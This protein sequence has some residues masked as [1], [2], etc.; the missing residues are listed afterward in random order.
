MELPQKNTAKER[1]ST[2]LIVEDSFSDIEIIKWAFKETDCYDITFKKSLKE[3]GLFLKD[4]KVDIILTD[5]YLSDG[6]GTE[7]IIK[8]DDEIII[9]TILMT[10][11]GSEE[12]AITAFKS[13]AFD[14]I[15][16][17]V[18]NIQNLPFVVGRVLREWENIVTR[19]KAEESLIISEKQLH[20]IFKES[21]NAICIT[22]MKTGRFLMI[23]NSFVNITGFSKNEIIGNYI[24]KVELFK[25]KT[26][27]NIIID[28]IL[29]REIIKNIEVNF[30]TK[31]KS[32]K[33]GLLSSVPILFDGKDAVLTLINDITAKKEYELELL[34]YRV[35]LE[36][37][38]EERTAELDN[39]IQQL[40]EE[41]TE[42]ERVKLSLDRSMIFINRIINS[43]GEPIFV[44]DEN[45]ELILF[46]EALCSL[47]GIE[48]SSITSNLNELSK[49]NNDFNIL[50][51]ENNVIF[52]FGKEYQC[53]EF[54]LDKEGT[55]RYILTHKALYCDDTGK[56]FIVGIISDLS[57]RKDAEEEMKNAFMKEKELNELKSRF[58]S[59]VSHEYRTPL[60][61][62]MSSAELLQMFSHKWDKAKQDELLIKIQ[63][64]VEY[65]TTLIDDVLLYNVLDTNRF[66]INKEAI[67]VVSF[68]K[69]IVNELKIISK[70]NVTVN[71]TSNKESL[72]IVSDKKFLL[73]IF[74][75]LVTNAIK[76]SREDT[77]IHIDLYIDGTVLY[78]SVEDHGYGIPESDKNS[79]F[80]PFFRGKNI[81]NIPGS[82]LGLSIVKN[83]L[84]ILKGDITYLSEE[85]VGTRFIIRI[86]F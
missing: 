12:T 46:N 48:R 79:L 81:S 31:A 63:E 62:I 13:G 60:T 7:L 19:K 20:T 21:P 55:N 82:G 80:E 1:R 43:I 11:H 76:Y 17:K 26:E 44:I 32:L 41:I 24:A 3:A 70:K 45:D 74:S 29:K 37:K 39:T 67:E 66:V 33:W 59:M 42:K 52:K 85:N 78:F 22:D 8:K 40:K 83:C 71:F 47:F 64:K 4:N 58:V 18:E 38:V 77:D 9:P 23:N 50:L 16:K 49:E 5:W 30:L 35:K 15:I 6:E 51:K 14:Y 2:I 54:Y 53:E 84:N 27:K 25:N 34:N 72:D 57:K 10:G 86:P 36:K 73:Q 69:S 56:K 28:K 75:N 65:L 68:V 61:A